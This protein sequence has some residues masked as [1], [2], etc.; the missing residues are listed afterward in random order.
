MST[1]TS[2]NDGCRSDVAL[3]AG[4]ILLAVVTSL[5]LC[6]RMTIGVDLTDESYYLSFLDGWLKTGFQYSNALGLH[7]TAEL[8]VFPFVKVFAAVQPNEEGLALFNR[9]IYL[10]VSLISGFC[11]F[12]FARTR[13][14]FPI[15]VLCGIAVT[16]FIPFSLPS[17]S[18]NTLGMLSMLCAVAAYA[19]FAETQQPRWLI[20]SAAAWMVSVIAYPTFVVVLASFLIAI[21]VV[22]VLRPNFRR[23][24]VWCLTF[25]IVGL[26]LLLS[27][28]GVN[29]F[30]QIIEFTNSSLQVSTGLGGKLSKAATLLGASDIFVT[31]CLAS[32][33]I[34]IFA[35]RGSRRSLHRWITGTVITGILVAARLAGPFL[36]ATSHDYVFLLAIAGTAFFLTEAITKARNDHAMTAY[37]FVG[38]FAGIVTSLTATNSIVNFAIGGFICVCVFLLAIF[39]KREV[40]RLSHLALLCVVV[41]LF[42]ISNFNFI[43]GEVVNPLSSAPAK[44]IENG[45]FA[46][47][48][49]TEDKV[50]AISQTTELLATIPGDSVAV[51]GR[52]P[53]IYLLTRMRPKTLSTWDFSQQNGATPK[54]ESAISRFYGLD[55]NLP[56]V[57][58][59]VTDPW[60]VAPSESGKQLQARYVQTS[61]IDT[62]QWKID[63]LVRPPL[64]K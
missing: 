22:P 54:I 23:Y 46:G 7:Q 30:M 52:F 43:Y 13:Q 58:L 47:L 39:P 51:I 29:R 63:V 44:R 35:G 50:R 37:F 53:S 25:Q 6:Y 62:G 26:G 19:T 41:A 20:T 18:Y 5:L 48:L 12:R 8:L 21:A 56:S 10:V 34:G 61:H 57:V 15:A 40:E 45:V 28:Y 60:T 3:R 42:L 55:A 64:M 24:V 49:T 17:P 38:L 11:F 4:M 36:Y 1:P 27:A 32:I 2:N 16:S 14:T 59:N 31:L 33:A 9:F